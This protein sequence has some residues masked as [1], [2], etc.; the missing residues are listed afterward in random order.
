LSFGFAG[1]QD[2]AGRRK[3]SF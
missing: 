1:F 3:I 2:W